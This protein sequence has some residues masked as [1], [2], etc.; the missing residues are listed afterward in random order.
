M[1]PTPK[2]TRV[3]VPSRSPLSGRIL[4]DDPAQGWPGT[5]LG[6]F[7]AGGLRA[8]PNSR[9]PV[10]GEGMPGVDAHGIDSIEVAGDPTLEA[11]GIGEVPRVMGGQD[12]H[13]RDRKQH[14]EEA[15]CP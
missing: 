7:S 9:A 8:A 2:M 13:R 11:I 6:T 4:E 5:P 12:R 1:V 15:K 14:Q 10:S 3:D